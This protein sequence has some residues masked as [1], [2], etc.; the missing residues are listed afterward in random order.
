M[1]PGMIH[2]DNK[3][4]GVIRDGVIIIYIDGVQKLCLCSDRKI[5]WPDGNVWTCLYG[6]EFMGMR[7]AMHGGR[8]HRH[9]YRV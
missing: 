2:I 8:M 9:V 7:V 3:Y 5:K 4:K 1:T 6:P